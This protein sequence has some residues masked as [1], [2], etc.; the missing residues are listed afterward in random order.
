VRVVSDLWF[1]QSIE[2]VL[3]RN[4]LIDRRVSFLLNLHRTTQALT[5][6]ALRVEETLKVAHAISSLHLSPSRIDIGK[7]ALKIREQ[8]VSDKD[9]AAF[10]EGEL[11]G[12]K[13]HQS[14]DPRDVVLY[15]FGRIG[16]L[17]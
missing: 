16:R 14:F 2:L 5:G 8:G 3:F 1:N 15:G 6:T 7:L 11:A 10:V 17:L 13:S 12:A 4:Q 9:I